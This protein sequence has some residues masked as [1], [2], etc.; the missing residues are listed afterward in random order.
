[1]F[2]V[3]NQAEWRDEVRHHFEKIK[4]EGTC[5]HRLD[6]ELIKRRR[7]EL[8]LAKMKRRTHKEYGHFETEDN[9]KQTTELLV[10]EEHIYNGYV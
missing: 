8:R 6:E 10:V 3:S 7:E 4:S 2:Y 1:M 9:G 5:L